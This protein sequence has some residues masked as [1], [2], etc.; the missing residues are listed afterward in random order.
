MLTLALPA[1]AQDD[2]TEAR[3]IIATAYEQLADTRYSYTLTMDTTNSVTDEEGQ[4]SGVRQ[5]YEIEGE[6]IGADYA[7]TITLTVTPLENEID[8]QA[9]RISRVRVDDRFYVR[10]G[11]LL[12]QQLGVA[13]VWWQMQDLLDEIGVDNV[14][15]FAAQQLEG[16]PTPL[17]TTLD[18]AL[19]RS[20]TELEPDDIDGVPVR[21][22][23]VEMKAIEMM[24]SAVEGTMADQ[25]T[26]F[27]ENL[28]LTLQS[29]LSIVYRLSIG[30]EDGQLYRS[31]SEAYTYLPFIEF[32]RGN[33]PDFD[34]ENTGVVVIDIDYTDAP[35]SIDT[36]EI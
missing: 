1:A 8:V 16:I 5:L 25:I 19:I 12:S 31:E 11:T 36:P 24:A 18:D 27:L 32:G 3:E 6:A 29:E 35:E 2:E 15:S 34:I 22:F 10:L 13:D 23:E 33:D 7:D 9:G 28:P 20:V 21:V 14:Q 26:A 17:A 4:T 30:T